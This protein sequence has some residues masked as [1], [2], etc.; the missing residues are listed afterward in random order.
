[1]FGLQKFKL[2]RYAL[3]VFLEFSSIND[4]PKNGDMGIICTIQIW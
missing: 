3:H 1:L 4:G 2:S